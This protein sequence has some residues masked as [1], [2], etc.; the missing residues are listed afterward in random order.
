[1]RSTGHAGYASAHSRSTRKQHFDATTA[2]CM[3]LDQLSLDGA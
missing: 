2:S 3:K 1:M